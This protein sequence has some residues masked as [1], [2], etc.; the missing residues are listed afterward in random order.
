MLKKELP[1]LQSAQQLA[2]LLLLIVLLIAGSGLRLTGADAA[3][4]SQVLTPLILSVQDAP[5]PFI[6]SD[7][8]MHLVYELWMTNF[9][10]LTAAVNQVAVIGDGHALHTLEAGQVAGR[11][12]PAGQ[13]TASGTIQS[14]GVSLLFIHLVLDRG[15]SAPRHLSHRVEVTVHDRKI[16]ESGGGVAVNHRP[17]AIIGPPL[18]G[19]NYISADSCCDAT[20]HT[21]A[22]L[23]VNGRVWV[24][25]R[26]AV[27][28]E[29]LDSSNRIYV[30]AKSDVNSY[31]IYG[32][33]VLAV[34][35]A[36]VIAALD[37]LPN[38]VP[39]KFPENLP[40]EQADGN[41]VILDLGGSNYALY[42]HL[43]PGSVAVHDGQRV[44]RGQ[45]IGLVGNSGN[46]IAPHLH[47]QLMDHP[48]SLA[49]NGLPYEVGAYHITG[50]SP[51]TAAFDEAEAK[52][53]PLAVK[54]V[55]PPDRRT[56]ALP[57]DQ[58]IISF[59]P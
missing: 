28:W 17:V 51:G 29:Q 46:T 2:P 59:S 26:Y 10:S 41:H 57:L 11:L 50:I 15:A 36:T 19:A 23:P 43:K 27:D 4:G 9:T 34:A 24:A 58:L 3:S 32:T 53:T 5:V 54:T 1:G 44:T 47:F 39:G 40:I 22:A 48:V 38:Q 18:R 35:N 33:Q 13:R 30:G 14:G 8:R 45:V 56:N 49:A 52:G 7:G 42:A 25:Q 55:S 31:K 6:G 37:G 21:R 20:R 12:Q 16:S